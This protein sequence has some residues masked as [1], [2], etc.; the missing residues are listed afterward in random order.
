MSPRDLESHH[1]QLKES[2]RELFAST[3]KMGGEEF[4]HQYLEKLTEEIDVLFG[5][6]AKH[7]EG[8]NIFAAARTPATLFAMVLAF[9]VISGAFSILGLYSFANF[10]N[11]LMGLSLITLCL[12]GYV[13]YSG[14]MRDIGAH[15]D[16]VANVIWANVSSLHGRALPARLF[17]STIP[18]SMHLC[19]R[20]RLE[21]LCN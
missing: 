4:S 18:C 20:V 19:L 5:N 2:A 12:W 15:I 11:L 8:K 13:R 17:R 7:N 10:C 3:R 9:Y 21:P 6:F 1:L 14:D 16:T